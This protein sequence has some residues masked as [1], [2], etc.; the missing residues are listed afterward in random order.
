MPVPT[1]IA[2]VPAEE[3]RQ[4]AADY[5]LLAM[6]CGY[7]E[8]VDLLLMIADVHEGEAAAASLEEAAP[9]AR[10]DLLA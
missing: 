10:P 2:R 6:E 5:R 7:P 8:G 4:R 9:I 1:T 3:L